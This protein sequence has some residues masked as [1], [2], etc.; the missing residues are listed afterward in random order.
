MNAITSLNVAFLNKGVKTDAFGDVRR[1][2]S[3]LSLFSMLFGTL[4][5]S[6]VVEAQVPAGKVSFLLGAAY[7]TRDDADPMVLTT[8]A[9]IN[10][11]DTIK[12]LAGGHVHVRFVDDALVSVRPNSRLTVSHYQFDSENPQASIIR[13]DLHEGQVRSIS[14]HGAKANREKFRLNTPIAAIGVRG[15]DF[16][17]SAAAAEVRAIVNEGAIVVAPFSESCAS[18]GVNRCANGV[19]LTGDSQY[20]LEFNALLERPRLVPINGKSVPGLE[21]ENSAEPASS[22]LGDDTVDAVD[23][24]SNSEG[25]AVEDDPSQESE[26]LGAVIEDMSNVSDEAELLNNGSEDSV[27]NAHVADRV[28][29]PSGNY[30]PAEP[31]SDEVLNQRQLVWGRWLAPVSSED[32]VVTDR[33]VAES[34]RSSTVGNVEYLLYR[35]DTDRTTL[36]ADLGVVGFSLV[37]AQATLTQGGSTSPMEVKDGWLVVD[38]GQRSFTTGLEL[39]HELTS[40][41]DISVEGTIGDNGY[42]NYRD[43]NNTWFGATTLDGTEASYYFSHTNEFGSIDGVTYWLGK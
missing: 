19:E 34:G 15:T 31:V 36:A 33:S 8:G 42:F 14:G 43:T 12:T 18:D 17:V 37:D 23:D 2:L 9:T 7:L 6:C 32:R 29:P 40:T 1:R 11:G 13:F 16:V 5:W 26:D 35:T 20:L 27:L 30:V 28:P 25:G 39:N 21:G 24:Q 10:A 4:L 41:V 3:V 22:D 38:F